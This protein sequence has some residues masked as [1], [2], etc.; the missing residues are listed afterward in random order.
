M[1]ITVVGYITKDTL[2]F[3]HSNW[4]VLESLGGALYTVTA[5]ASLTEE[6]INLVSNAGIDI[7]YEVINALARFPSVDTSGIHRVEQP[8]YHCYILFASEYGAQY[9]ETLEVPIT[10]SQVQPFL[11]DSQFILVSPMTGFELDLSTLQEI[12]DAA[13]CPV[14][15]DYHILAL[16]RDK[17]GNRFL[18][19]RPDWLQWCAACDHLQLNQ[20][21]A[22]SLGYFIESERDMLRF[23]EL[24]LEHGVASVAVTLGARGVLVAWRDAGRTEVKWIGATKVSAVIDPTGCGDVFAAGFIV[25]FLRTGDFLTSYEFANR[26]AGLKCGF[27]GFDG[28]ADTLCPG[29]MNSGASLR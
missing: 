27:S 23:A 29:P 11:E 21:E 12:R 10:F 2:I 20:F 25:H 28:L 15:F 1:A 17:L 18:Q 4:R 14:Y 19:R 3:P 7:F 9:D 6:R 24:I 5:L 16:G 13:E 22:E 8:H 26:I